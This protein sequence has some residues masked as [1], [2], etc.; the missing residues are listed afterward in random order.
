MEISKKESIVSF[1]VYFILLLIVISCV[2]VLKANL[3]SL[4]L[5]IFAI[6]Y[7]VIG[8]VLV[9]GLLRKTKE[10]ENKN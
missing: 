5:S 4:I 3:I 9:I 6:L 1:F 8:S 7:I 2:V 10:N